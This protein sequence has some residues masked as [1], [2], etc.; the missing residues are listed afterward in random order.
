[1]VKAQVQVAV[2]LTADKFRQPYDAGSNFTGTLK[3]TSGNA[4]IG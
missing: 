3:D 2:V 1:M 4:I